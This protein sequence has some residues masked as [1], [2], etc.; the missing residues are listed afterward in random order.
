MRAKFSILEPGV[1]LMRN[2]RIPVKM[3]LMGLLLLVPLLL[4]LV[5]M[6]RG[7]RADIGIASAEIEGAQLASG[8]T[9]LVTQV[10]TTRGLT[11]RAM[12]S[13]TRAT[14]DLP[15][16]RDAFAA[17]QRELETTLA[18]TR[19]FDA[20]D[21]WSGCR[22][23]LSDLAAGRHAAARQEAFAEH[24]R[25][26]E[27]LRQM[28]LLV[29]ERSGLL[30]DPQATTFFL[31]DIAVERTIPLSETLGLT[32]GQGA[33][34]LVRGEISNTERA[35]LLG[36]MDTYEQKLTDLQGKVAALQ[37]NGMPAPASWGVA[38][39]SGKEF[40]A[41]VR[42]V[43]SAE[44]LAAD[45]VDFFDRGT[46]ALA[47]LNRF[48]T[49]V[50]G[51]LEST[52]EQRRADLQRGMVVQLGLSLAGSALAVYLAL[53]FYFSFRRSFRALL[54]GVHAAADGNL[55]HKVEIPGRDELAGMGLMLEAM[56]ARLSAMVAEIRSSAVR[57]G[58]AGQEV[59]ASSESLAQRTEEQAASLRQTVVTVSQLSGAV[60]SNAAEVHQLDGIAGQLRVQAEVGG[61][62]MRATVD[63]MASLAS[64]S[65]RVAEIVGVID[66]ISFQT[67]ILALN[68]AVEAARAGESG[69]GFAVVAGEVRQLAKRSGE[70]AAEIRKLIGAS[71][72]QVKASVGRIENVSGTLDALVSGVQDVSQRL[73][74]IASASAEQSLGLNE[75]RASVGSLDDITRQNARMVEGSSLA[76]QQLVERA[77]LLS[78][79]VASIRLRQGGADEAQQLVERALQLVA[80]AGPQAAF[81]RMR[82]AGGGFV[83]RDL[84]VFA[85]D[86]E[87][88]Y[89]LHASKPEMEGRRVHDV[90]GIDGPR[91][92][93][94]AWSTTESGP[95]WIDYEILNRES[96]IVQPKLSYVVRLDDRLVIGC[97][98]YRVVRE[99]KAAAAAVAPARATPVATRALARA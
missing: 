38:M 10:Q 65:K 1:R 33:A 22:T 87:G 40:A 82:M 2:L 73:R 14:A 20:A 32:R 92:V 26:I 70:A 30:L 29:G 54:K 6:V 58:Q 51:A 84:Y 35:Q 99:P 76:S 88:V 52:L 78:E 47:G 85:V 9:A 31:M 4:A 37:R 80:Q 24:T 36:R 39:S 17:A 25:A 12:Q 55:E 59:A 79:A 83:D 90:P 15:K 43:L 44:T 97:G 42:S 8:I 19:A 49:D 86:R 64:S 74:G 34:I 93:A 69:R 81:E 21:L 77:G 95:G 56:N 89:R 66:G 94:D 7:M 71:S 16:A 48:D 27:C 60:A 62:A 98:I 13:D 72:E 18:Q 53:A 63:S 5:T 67:N 68:A 75:M 50:L 23:G 45:P 57:V 46:A 41:H 11:N 3:G 61:V 28:L 91:F 96:G